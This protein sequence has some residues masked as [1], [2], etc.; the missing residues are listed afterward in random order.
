VS[1]GIGSLR[2]DGVP[3]A[4]GARN[5]G[6]PGRTSSFWRSDGFLNHERFIPFLTLAV[7]RSEIRRA[8]DRQSISHYRTVDE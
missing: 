6:S 3:F 4:V 2:S 1:F 7:S 5:A 8:N